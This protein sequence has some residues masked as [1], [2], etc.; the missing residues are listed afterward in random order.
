MPPKMFWSKM[1]LAA[2]FGW[3]AGNL[4]DEQGNVDRGGAGRHAGRI[5]AEVAAV[6][7]DEGLVAGEARMQIGEIRRTRAVESRLPAMP[8]PFAAAIGASS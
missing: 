1:V 5:V 7:F 4:A 8:G 6:G 2:L 3:P